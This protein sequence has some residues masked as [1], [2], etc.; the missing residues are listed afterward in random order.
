MAEVVPNTDNSDV[1]ILAIAWE[2]A[3]ITHGAMLIKSGGGGD[4]GQKEMTNAVIKTY[5][6]IKNLKPVE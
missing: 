3:K 1:A 4:N 6:A 2:I 5:D